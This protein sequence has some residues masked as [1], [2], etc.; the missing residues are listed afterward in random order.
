ML[1][2]GADIAAV[3]L[4]ELTRLT[5]LTRLGADPAAVRALLCGGPGSVRR[6]RRRLFLAGLPLAAI[7]ADQFVPAGS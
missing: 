4:A 5:G 7:G 2:Q 6:M 3:V 1:G